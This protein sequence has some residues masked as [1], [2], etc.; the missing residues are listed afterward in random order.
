[1]L[2]ATNVID[3]A[4]ANKILFAFIIIPMITINDIT[5]TTILIF[6]LSIVC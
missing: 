6:I 4:I 2:P 5:D 3:K 1:M